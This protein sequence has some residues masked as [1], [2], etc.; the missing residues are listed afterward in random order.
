MVSVENLKLLDGTVSVYCRKVYKRL[1]YG[2][3]F[4]LERIYKYSIHTYV[5][6]QLI[7]PHM[8]IQNNYFL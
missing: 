1:L 5:Y 6:L 7:P 8:Y 2:G 3:Y 4:K